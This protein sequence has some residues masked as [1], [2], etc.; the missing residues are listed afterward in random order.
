M[1]IVGERLRTL[2]ESKGLS[3]KRVA[4]LFDVGQSSIFRYEKGESSAPYHILNQYADYF[5]VSMDYIFGRTDSPQRNDLKGKCGSVKDSSEVDQFLEMCFDP[6]SPMHERLKNTL[7]Q[8]LR[9]Q[10]DE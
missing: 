3:Q 1:K 10:H 7:R 2:R 4:K 6:I 9:E 8:M 5:E